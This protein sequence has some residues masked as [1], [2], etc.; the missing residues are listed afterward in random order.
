MNSEILK[1][2]IPVNYEEVGIFLGASNSTVIN[3]PT[4]VSSDETKFWGTV[5]YHDVPTF[6]GRFLE[7][8]KADYQLSD[9]IV[10]LTYTN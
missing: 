7:V 8:D 1:E 10:K 2:E 5:L 6:I 3:D 4:Q 9:K